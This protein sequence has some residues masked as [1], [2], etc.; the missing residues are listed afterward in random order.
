MMIH[1]SMRTVG[2]VLIPGKNTVTMSRMPM[3][4]QGSTSV[5][6]AKRQGSETIDHHCTLKPIFNSRLL[7]G[8]IKLKSTRE[9]NIIKKYAE[10]PG[11]IY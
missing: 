5:G 1:V 9:R 4:A 10:K 7:T 6:S 8:L 3:G 2:L 11:K